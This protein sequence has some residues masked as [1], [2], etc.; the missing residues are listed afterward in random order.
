MRRTLL[1]VVLVLTACA[2]SSSQGPTSHQATA[3]ES[4]SEPGL[5]CHEETPTG[6]NISRRV[7]RTPEEIERQQRET[8][9]LARSRGVADPPPENFR[10][11]GK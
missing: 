8:Q 11:T 6:S 4:G 9:D 5:I 3:S 10:P 1:T 7:C 2:T